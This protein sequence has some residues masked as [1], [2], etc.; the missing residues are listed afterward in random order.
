MELRSTRHHSDYKDLAA[1]LEGL[2]LYEENMELVEMR[3]ILTALQQS[4]DNLDTDDNAVPE[5]E[6]EFM[7]KRSDGVFNST[8]LKDNSEQSSGSESVDNPGVR[9]RIFVQAQVHHSLDWI[10]DW[11]NEQEDSQPAQPSLTSPTFGNNSFSSSKVR[12]QHEAVIMQQ[13]ETGN[14]EFHERVGPVSIRQDNHCQ[15]H[16]LSTSFSMSGSALSSDSQVR[17]RHLEL[18]TSSA[19][20]SDQEESS[21]LNNCDELSI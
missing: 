3:D 12:K 10:P 5:G 1:I 18:S 2:G 7:S 4:V 14:E 8:M 13:S 16:S 6:T 19:V 20:V 17:E 11:W 15:E 9:E 21:N